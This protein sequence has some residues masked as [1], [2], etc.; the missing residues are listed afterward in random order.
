MAQQHQTENSNRPK[1]RKRR[2]RIRRVLYLGWF[3]N[4]AMFGAEVDIDDALVFVW[5]AH[6]QVLVP[7]L[8][9]VSEIGQRKSESKIGEERK[10]K[11]DATAMSPRRMR[12][13]RQNEI[14]IKNVEIT[15]IKIKK[16]D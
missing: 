11:T 10:G 15:R 16:R 1:C 12:R 4:D 3:G 5:R 8:I 13:R 7:V 14:K 9:D 6:G 2:R